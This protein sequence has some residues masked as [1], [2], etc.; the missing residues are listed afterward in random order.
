MVAA[1]SVTNEP[2]AQ[3]R[4]NAFILMDIRVNSTPSKGQLLGM[5]ENIGTWKT[6][7]A[8]MQSYKE[9]ALKLKLHGVPRNDLHVAP[10][11]V[12]LNQAGCIG[13]SP[14]MIVRGEYAMQMEPLV[15][16]LEA[17]D[18]FGHLWRR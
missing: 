2:R 12:R 7:G 15:G 3:Q 5:R 8:T 17:N 13:I 9:G 16:K 4:E 11:D 10:V 18:V 1:A 6:F 14:Q